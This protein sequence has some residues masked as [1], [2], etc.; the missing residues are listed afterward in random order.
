MAFFC[1]LIFIR[2]K[3]VMQ[4]RRLVEKVYVFV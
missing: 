2:V 4:K 1:I 3:D